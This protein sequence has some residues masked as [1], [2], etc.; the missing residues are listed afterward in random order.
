MKLKTI[1]VVMLIILCLIVLLQNTQIV[2]LRFLFWE[3]SIS[4]IFLL[5]LLIIFGFIIGYVAAKLEKGGKSKKK[6][7]E[8]ETEYKDQS[9]NG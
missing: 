8:K 5:P 4:R 9:E 6:G 1:I 7:G 3:A 2:T